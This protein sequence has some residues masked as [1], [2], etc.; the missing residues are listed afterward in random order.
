LVAIDVCER[1]LGYRGEVE[2]RECVSDTGQMGEPGPGALVV[3]HHDDLRRDH[4]RL[5]VRRGVHAVALQPGADLVALLIVADV[6]S[7]QQ[8]WHVERGQ[9]SSGHGRVGGDGMLDAHDFRAI[10]RERETRHLPQL[11]GGQ[12]AEA[13]HR[14]ERLGGHR[15]LPAVDGK[16]LTCVDV[17]QRH[18]AVVDHVGWQCIETEPGKLAALVRLAIL[19]RTFPLPDGEEEGGAAAAGGAVHDVG[20]LDILGFDA[21]ADLFLGFADEGLDDGFACFQVAGGQVPGSVFEAGV[22]TTA[23]EDLAETVDQEEMHVAGQFVA[24]GIETAIGRYGIR[25]KYTPKCSPDICRGDRST[26]WQTRF[27]R[28]AYNQYCTQLLDQ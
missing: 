7:K 28:V 8:C 24:P 15:Q 12:V 16:G 25:H 18:A 2:R 3:G 22:L 5:H 1:R 11:G 20:E 6:I 4:V 14:A 17:F 21:D 27:M 19:G 10:V 23:E 26:I 9:H 13:R